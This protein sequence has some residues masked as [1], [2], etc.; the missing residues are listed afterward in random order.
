MPF[1]ALS[2]LPLI[3]IPQAVIVSVS[4]IQNIVMVTLLLQFMFSVIGVQLFKVSYLCDDL[5]L[6][7]IIMFRIC[8]NDVCNLSK[9][10][11]QRRI[12]FYRFQGKLFM[13]TDESKT[14][15]AECQVKETF[16]VK[17]FLERYASEI[18]CQ[19]KETLFAKLFREIFFRVSLSRTST[20]T[21]TSLSCRSGSG[22]YNLKVSKKLAKKKN[23]I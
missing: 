2:V 1:W 3:W 8:Y 19:V 13:C 5:V 16:F 15:E 18:E 14:T 21:S 4:S 17:F 11:L 12:I 7:S 6:I 22:T 10:L 23:I 20:R 9:K